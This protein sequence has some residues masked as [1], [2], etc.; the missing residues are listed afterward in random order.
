MSRFDRFDV[1]FLD[2]KLL[3]AMPLEKFKECLTSVFNAS[4]PWEN[5]QYDV[6]FQDHYFEYAQ[7]CVIAWDGDIPIA[8]SLAFSDYYEELPVFYISGIW[9]SSDYKSQGLGKLII[10]LLIE[11]GM[12]SCFANTKNHQKFIALRTQ[13]PQIYEYFNKHYDVYPHKDKIANDTI[14]AIGLGVHK[15]YSPDKIYDLNRMI[16]RSVFPKGIIVGHLHPAKDD[17]FNL[18]INEH[19]DVMGGDSY[20]LVIPY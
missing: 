8:L 18:Y 14:T 5:P 17:T 11:R 1:E 7:A 6:S 4:I 3:D 15:K 9:V 20:I 16:I 13:N 12:E 19:L 10:E 2:K